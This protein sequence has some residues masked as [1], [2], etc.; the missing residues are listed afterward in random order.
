MSEVPLYC[1]VLRTRQGLCV[2]SDVFPDS[3]RASSSSLFLSSL[4]LSDAKVYEPQIRARLGT[5]SH[6]CELVVLKLR[7]VPIGTAPHVPTE[8]VW[9][10]PLLQQGEGYR[11]T[12]LTRNRTT[13]GPCSRPLLRVLGGPRGVGVVL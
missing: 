7:T 1:C 12:S 6:F 3:P 9:F 5:A 13:L 10:L 2:F 11:G 4:E 8:V